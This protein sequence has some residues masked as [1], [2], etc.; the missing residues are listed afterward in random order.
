MEIT[1]VDL[2]GLESGGAGWVEARDAVTA[3]M[4]AHGFV[5]VAHDAL[6]PELRQALF[7]RAMPEIFALPPEAKQRNVST[8]GPFRGYISNVPGTNWESVR[9]SEVTDA[10]RVRDF[11]DLLWP[12]GN[13]AFCDTIMSAV[14][15]VWELQRTVET[16]I[17]EGLGVGEEH[18]GAHLDTLAH[19]VRL[20]RYG[21]PPDAETSMSLQAHRDDSIMT[22]I[23]QHGVE[24]LEV[25]AQDGIWLAVPPEPD[26]FTFVAGELF[27]VVTNGRVPGCFHRVRTPSNRER[28]SA[29][30]GCPGKDGVLLSAMD[31]LVDDEHPLLYR[32][33]TNDGYTTFRHSDEGRKAS[34]PLKAFCGV[35][36][37][38][39]RS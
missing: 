7:G 26:L 23:V 24:G 36:K 3:S 2:R 15:N 17:L 5:V 9:L 27:T 4:V 33:C 35:E 25:Q 38:D 10:G 32:L 1:K 29:L 30:F 39:H 31:E 8:V 20:S 19:V 37:D 18:I 28:L 21:P 22:A 34:D 14:K 12:Q 6:G 11:A 16:M 13:P